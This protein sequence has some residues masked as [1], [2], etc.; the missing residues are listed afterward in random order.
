MDYLNSTLRD[1]TLD[2][3]ESEYF[4]LVVIGGGI[5]GAGILREASLRGF[6]VALLEADDFASGTS[7]KSTKLI[8][9]GL[10]YLAMGH[11][12]VVREAARERKRVN[13]LAPHLAEPQWLMVPGRNLLE[14][15]KYRIGINLY[16]YLGQVSG[17]DLHFNLSGSALREFEPMLDTRHFPRACVYREYLTDDARLVI[18]NV[19]A[20]IAAGGIAANKCPVTGV[21]HEGSR[22]SHVLARCQDTG[23]N[24]RV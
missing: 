3:L 4:D 2:A 20:G 15:L 14:D 5:T 9:G 1:K 12:H 23:R 7:S 21:E 19:R 18:A 10:R 11:I 22:I 13:R 17:A 8:H 6:S 24:I 16:E